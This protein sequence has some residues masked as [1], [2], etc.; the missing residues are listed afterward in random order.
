M[1]GE[2][3]RCRKSLCEEQVHQR[4]DKGCTLGKWDEL[5][6][7]NYAALGVLPTRQN[8]KSRDETSSEIH[9]RL[10]PGNDLMMINR[11]VQVHGHIDQWLIMAVVRWP[12]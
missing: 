9:N 4:P 5:R 6:W 1:L 7:E 3:R 8:L 2:S 10:K 11:F 12:D